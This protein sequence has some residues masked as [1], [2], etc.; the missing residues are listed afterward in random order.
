MPPLDFFFS[1]KRKAIVKRES[2]Q[3]D[4][5]ITKRQ[6]MLYD[7]ND[8]DDTEFAK[9]VAGSLG[10]FS[11]TNQW[12]VDNLARTTVTEVSIGRTVAKDQIYHGTDYKEQMSQ[13]F[14]Q[15][16]AHDRQQIQQ[17]AG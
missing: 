15:I 3:K 5:V 16:R 8:R 2:H 7:G 14:E 4:G 13:D 1:K 9:E 11:T 6:R 10:A 17:L 12:S